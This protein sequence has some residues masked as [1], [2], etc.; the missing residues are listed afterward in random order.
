[1]VTIR[2]NYQCEVC[3][4][5]TLVR[6]QV[7]WLDS[8]PVRFN[9]LK[10]GILI[11]GTMYQ[12]QINITAHLVLEN[13]IKVTNTS[14]DYY[15][16]ASGELLTEKLQKFTHTETMLPTFFKTGTITMEDSVMEFREK[17]STYLWIIENEWPT[18]RRINELWFNKNYHY[19]KKELRKKITNKQYP[20]NNDIQLLTSIRQLNILSMKNILK[21][22]FFNVH[23]ENIRNEISLL[24]QNQNSELIDLMKHFS[25][26]MNLYEKKI[27]E[28]INQFN[29]KFK[30]MIPVF[31]L[32]FYQDTKFDYNKK[33]I[34][35]VSFEDLKQFY[36][37][38]F[39]LVTELLDIVVA[40]NNLKYRNNYQIMKS[41]RKDIKTLEKFQ[42]TSKGGKLEFIDRSEIFDELIY[43]TIS[44]QLRN[45]IG[46]NS[47]DID[48][49]EQIIQFSSTKSKNSETST[50][51]L[52]DFTK[53]CWE[54]FQTLI[55]ISELVYQ[56]RRFYYI[57][58]GL[59]P[60]YELIFEP[61]KV[62]KKNKTI[63][64]KKSINKQRKSSKRKNRK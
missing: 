35:T 1:M 20:F 10:C 37:D 56:T 19:L 53:A 30:Y 33:G 13:V 57:H 63:N 50:L 6:V 29:Q 60:T 21:D 39:E 22:E 44:N 43:P 54:L 5:R 49:K 38:I 25:G 27:F 15:I 31:G 40:Y 16:E 12:D 11:T 48:V 64:K 42:N 47:Y 59:T 18:Y 4:A 58:L 41:K 32:D 51:S 9:C 36:V 8:H 24:Y 26:S 23:T 55:N 62:I 3:K 2:G 14:S 52:I 45:A 34:T 17:V 61:K 28:S 7:G 46:H